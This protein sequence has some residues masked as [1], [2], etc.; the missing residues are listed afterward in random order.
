MPDL[1]WNNMEASTTL[2][3]VDILGARFYLVVKVDLSN[4]TNSNFIGQGGLAIEYIVLE[5][6]VYTTLKKTKLDKCLGVDEIP[7]WFLQAIGDPLVQALTAITNQCWA[8]EYFPKRFREART[9][10]IQKPRRP[11]YSNLGA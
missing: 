3:K 4:I 6:K 9:I 1:Q 7:N 2:G 8:A 10:V 11:N 5:D